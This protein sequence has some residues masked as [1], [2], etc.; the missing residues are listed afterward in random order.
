MNLLSDIYYANEYISL[1]L[2]SDEEIFNFEYTD[3]NKTFINKAIKRRISRI[4]GIEVNDE[5]YDLETAYGYGGY[6][7]DTDDRTFIG[8]A[9]RKYEE[10]CEEENIIAE[11]IRFNPFNSFPLLYSDILDFN[12]YDRDTV[13]INLS[14]E[15]EKIK[16]NYSSSLKRNINKAKRHGLEYKQLEINE[17]NI[18][19]F[20]TLYKATMKRKNALDFYFFDL[21]YFKT[22]LTIRSVQLHCIILNDIIVNMVITFN[23]GSLIYYH[24][25]ATDSEYY[26]LNPNPLLFDSLIKKHETSNQYLYLG[27]GT[28]SEESDHLLK[29]KKKFSEETKPFY[30]AGKIFNNEIYSRYVKIWEQQ[31]D[32]EAKYFL[33]YRLDLT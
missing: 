21:S 12:L 19:K 16:A 23:S 31:G 26:H 8:K 24:L 32:R 22:L 4:G 6:Y 2:K 5:F 28:T 7:T 33:K 11:F 13:V 29:F 17:E 3:N 14:H 30:I 25:G 20:Y 15:H 27:G 1:Y 18:L 9:I 10:K